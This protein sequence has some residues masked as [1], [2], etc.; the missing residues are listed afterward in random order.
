MRR[1]TNKNMIAYWEKRVAELESMRPM[2]QGEALSEKTS[3]DA[4]ADRLIAEA[5][6]IRS[7]VEQGGPRGRMSDADRA[8][9]VKLHY[10]DLRSSRFASDR[11]NH[12]AGLLRLR[13][14]AM[15][16][17]SD[18]NYG[19]PLQASLSEARHRLEYYRSL[20]RMAGK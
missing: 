5:A 3:L 11:L 20:C 17:I 12:E 19:A 6:A 7:T 15:Q 9:A 13:A 16:R 18:A 8:N 14:D 10:A 4:E 1:I 2:T